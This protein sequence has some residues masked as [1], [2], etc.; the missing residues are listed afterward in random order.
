MKNQYKYFP[1]LLFPGHCKRLI[2]PFHSKKTATTKTNTT[3]TSTT[4]IS[5]T[6]TITTQTRTKKENQYDF[7]SFLDFGDITCALRDVEWSPICGTF[8][9]AP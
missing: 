7:L 3:K 1:G 6:K 2:N 4:K 5:T 8:N 9:E